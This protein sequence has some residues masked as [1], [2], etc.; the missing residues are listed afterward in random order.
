MSDDNNLVE[1]L[2]KLENPPPPPPKSEPPTPNQPND[3]TIVKLP[4]G[5]KIELGED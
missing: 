1:L 5:R 3:G 4:D 2:R